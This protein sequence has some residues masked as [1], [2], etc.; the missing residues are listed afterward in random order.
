MKKIV[1]HKL[2]FKLNVK[3]WVEFVWWQ[4]NSKNSFL[5]LKNVI[6][7][8]FK[9]HTHEMYTWKIDKVVCKRE[10]ARRDDGGEVVYAKRQSIET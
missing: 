8:L 2:T 5:Q 3:L 7:L 1:E 9:R 4:F 6:N 10:R